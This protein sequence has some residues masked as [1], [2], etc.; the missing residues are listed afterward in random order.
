MSRLRL[1]EAYGRRDSDYDTETFSH[2][3]EAAD[4]Q[5]ALRVF[6]E[7]VAADNEEEGV[8]E[9]EWTSYNDGIPEFGW[10]TIFELKPKGTP[11]LVAAQKESE[12]IFGTMRSLEDWEEGDEELNQDFTEEELQSGP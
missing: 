4:I 5:E 2:I 6:N 8:H 7:D 12:R 1:F 11:G 9:P 10:F 3:I